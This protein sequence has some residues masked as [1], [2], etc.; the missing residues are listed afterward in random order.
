MNGGDKLA[1]EVNRLSARKVVTT[2]EPGMYADGG[3]LY[4]RVS[5]GRNAGKRWVFIYRRPND[6]KRCE[7]G[8]GGAAAVSLKHARKKAAETRALLADGH[9]PRAIKATRR[10]TPTFGEFAASFLA[11]MEP[12][13]RNDKHRAQWRMTLEVYAKPLHD[14]PVDQVTTADVLGVLTPIWEKIPETASRL[15]GRVENILDAAKVRGF[16]SG[17]NPAAWRGHLE[18]TLPARKKL[19]R[20]HHRAMPI[21]DLPAFLTQLRLREAV[22]ARCLEFAILTVARTSEALKTQWQEL[23]LKNR[24]WRLPPE[25]MLKADREHRVPLTA[26]G[27][28]ILREMQTL[29]ANDPRSLFVF[30]G[31]R[32]GKPLS[33]S[34]LEMILR[35]LEVESTVHG[36]RSTFRDWAGNRTAFPRELAEHALSHQVGNKVEQAYRRDDALERRRELMEAW[37]EFLESASTDPIPKKR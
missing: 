20:G 3:G 32:R 7:I 10:E 31:Q 4:L 33:S 23:D 19:T 18:H 2:V 35:R 29:R 21:D 26:R 27:I 30:P 12:R 14:I 15:R 22:A 34:A 1:K 8:L 16:R 6:G 9:D 5:K 24:V 28:E 36:F 11:T 25:R 17:Q 13:W 37:A